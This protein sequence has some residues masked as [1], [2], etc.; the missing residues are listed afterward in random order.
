MAL[1]R[2]LFRMSFGSNV[3]TFYTERTVVLTHNDLTENK[4]RYW[5]FLKPKGNIRY[6]WFPYSLLGFLLIR[7][8][9]W[10][11]WLCKVW[12]RKAGTD[13]IIAVTASAKRTETREQLQVLITSFFISSIS[14]NWFVLGKR[15]K[16]TACAPG[17]VAFLHKHFV[18]KGLWI[19]LRY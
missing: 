10:G 14:K 17:D 2:K 16:L 7:P 12:C 19:Q 3:C 4:L 18:S 15:W 5:S 6:Q 1:E 9:L 8:N 13:L 11:F